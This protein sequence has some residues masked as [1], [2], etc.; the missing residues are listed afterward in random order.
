MTGAVSSPPADRMVGFG[1]ALPLY[2]K[3]YAA[4]NGRSSR[5]AYWWLALILILISIPASIIDMILFSSIV[6]STN[7]SGPVAILFSLATFIPSLAIGV[8]RLHDVGRSGWWL[9]IIFTI[10]GILLL[11]YWYVQPGQRAENK[12]GPDKEAGR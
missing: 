4:F 2:L 10:V 8:R 5:G 12:F 3:N 9:L 6:A 11:I 7:G 1:E